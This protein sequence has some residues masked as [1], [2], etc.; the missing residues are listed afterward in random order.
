MSAILT[1]KGCIPL[2]EFVKDPKHD[3]KQLK[4]PLLMQVMKVD[5]I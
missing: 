4:R 3:F 5:A 1:N 2:F